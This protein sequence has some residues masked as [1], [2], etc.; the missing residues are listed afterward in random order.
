MKEKDWAIV[1]G[2]ALLGVF[3]FKYLPSFNQS[4]QT[5]GGIPTSLPQLPLPFQLPNP[6]NAFLP[7]PNFLPS[8]QQILDFQK[9]LLTTI[10]PKPQINYET[11]PEEYKP[12][13]EAIN[14]GATV[15]D[16]FSS[17]TPQQE[18]V[19]SNYYSGS[20][21]LTQAI[22]QLRTLKAPQTTTISTTP[23]GVFTSPLA[24]SSP[25]YQ[26]VKPVT[27]GA[28]YSGV[29]QNSSLA[30]AKVVSATTQAINKIKNSVSKSKMG[31][32]YSI[33]PRQYL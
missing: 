31:S 7:L 19:R 11:K 17:G 1:G 15:N 27:S 13:V 14:R 23:S 18:A 2:I 22:S 8:G 9:D 6:Q 25:L 24:Q 10:L 33:N 21:N 30:P 12:T 32:G 20:I 4:E 5:S 28:V 16:P 26:A 29:N 3:A